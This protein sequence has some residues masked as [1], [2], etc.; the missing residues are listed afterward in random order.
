ML[1]TA[2]LPRELL[3][4]S[5]RPI[6]VRVGRPIPASEFPALAG[7]REVTEY[8]RWRT[9]MLDD[10]AKVHTFP[11]RL[12]SFR[13]PARIVDAPPQNQVAVEIARLSSERK[14]CE[15]GDLSVYVAAAGEI[16]K[17]LREIGR[18]RE[19]AFREAGE[20]TGR[21]IDLDRFDHHY[22]HVFAWN[23]T[24]AELVGAA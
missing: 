19:I 10:S 11:P 21:A 12:P 3:N 2:S 14:L 17:V 24:K 16:P 5:G 8:L 1:R 20:G 22:R 7:D 9:Y 23:R 18:L 6:R 4:K 15:S 13:K